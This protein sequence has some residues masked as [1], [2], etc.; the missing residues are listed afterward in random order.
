MCTNKSVRI[1]KCHNDFNRKITIHSQTYNF[2]IF[3]NW[4]L[5]AVVDRTT[6]FVYPT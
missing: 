3:K 4:T 6:Y 2:L 5:V 1:M